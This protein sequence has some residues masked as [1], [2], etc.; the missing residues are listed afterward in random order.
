MQNFG[1][2]DIERVHRWRRSC[3]LGHPECNK[4]LSHSTT[5]DDSEVPLPTR[6]IDVDQNTLSETKGKCGN[7][8]ILSHR[9]TEE[10]FN[11]RTTKSNY[12][13]KGRICTHPHCDSSTMSTPL[14][15]DMG[16]LARQLGIKYVWID[17]ICITQD[18]ADDWAQESVKMADYY[19]N[20]WLTVQA[21][22]AVPGRGLIRKIDAGSLPEIARLPYRN[23]DGDTDGYV[24]LQG[25]HSGALYDT[26]HE[27]YRNNDIFRRGWVFQETQLSR[28][29]IR[30]TDFGCSLK[31]NVGTMQTIAGEELYGKIDLIEIGPFE[32]TL[33]DARRK[34]KLSRTRL[35]NW[36]SDRSKTM[37]RWREIVEDFSQLDLK[38][39]DQD[40][41]VALAGI[42]TE[43]GNVL[44]RLDQNSV[45]TIQLPSPRYISGHWFPDCD[46][47]WEQAKPTL[48]ENIRLKGLPTWSWASVGTLRYD[49]LGSGLGV[50]WP[51]DKK[52]LCVQDLCKITDVYA[53]PVNQQDEW[54]PAFDLAH[55]LEGSAGYGNEARFTML[56]SQGRIY[57]VHINGIF[58]NDLEIRAA[59]DLTGYG[60][61][62][63][64]PWRSVTISQSSEYASGWASVEWPSDSVSEEVEGMEIYALHV[65]SIQIKSNMMLNLLGQ[66]EIAHKVLYLTSTQIPGY[67][68]CFQ[69]VGAGRLFGTEMFKMYESAQDTDIWLV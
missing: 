11:A 66:F 27:H 24:Y 10:T 30:F 34:E 50:R 1:P 14:F 33:H 47:L 19:Q 29:I 38:Y 51:E 16:N 5:F 25:H 18:D 2:L 8:L 58:E 31:C 36:T 65:K 7:Y 37:D 46:L 4:T 64:V 23:R 32:I 26:W 21:A 49:G 17:S 57:R 48:I 40:R 9:W 44:E 56:R 43:I 62:N 69:R 42:A 55:P 39:L 60:S 63:E 13:C 20:A 68:R 41:L 53:L 52:G 61:D 3:F 22:S 67:E 15:S 12:K 45:N 35:A 54:K 6:C 28:R 59:M